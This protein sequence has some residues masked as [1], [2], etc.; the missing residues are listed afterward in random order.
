MCVYGTLDATM[1]CKCPEARE[2][3]KSPGAGVANGHELPAV[4]AGNKL[5]SALTITEPA[6]QSL[7]NFNALNWI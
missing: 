6:L 4:S 2:G 7:L 5:G 1:E 3:V